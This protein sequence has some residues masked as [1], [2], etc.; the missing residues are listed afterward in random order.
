M[1]RQAEAEALLPY[2]VSYF[3]RLVRDVR[4]TRGWTQAQLAQAATMPLQAVIDFEAGR[5]RPALA[6]N[7]MRHLIDAMD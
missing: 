6:K 7:T 2:E 3:A 1:A 4:E 5:I